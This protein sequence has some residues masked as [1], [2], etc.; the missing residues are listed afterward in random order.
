MFDYS[1]NKDKKIPVICIGDSFRSG[2]FTD[3]SD[4]TIKFAHSLIC[5]WLFK[6]N[7]DAFLSEE[8]PEEINK[9]V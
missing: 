3:G 6:F 1:L 2:N 8:E 7:Y 5:A 9:S 4:L